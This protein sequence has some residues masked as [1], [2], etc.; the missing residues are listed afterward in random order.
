MNNY[1]DHHINNLKIMIN[2]L[3]QHFNITTNY[4]N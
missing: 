2:Q 3:I 4:I 1:E